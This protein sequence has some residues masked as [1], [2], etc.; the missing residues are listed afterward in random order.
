MQYK[1][2][3]DDKDADLIVA[4]C[5]DSDSVPEAV[6]RIRQQFPGKSYDSVISLLR[7]RGKPMPKELVKKPYTFKKRVA[8][9][10]PEIADEDTSPESE[11]IEEEPSTLRSERIPNI[12]EAAPPSSVRIERK[13]LP[14]RFWIDE[15]DPDDFSPVITPEND[16][17]SRRVLLI[18]DTHRPYHSRRAFGLLLK[19]AIEII[20][21]DTLVILGDFGDFYAASQHDKDP[22]RVSK[23][24]EELD[25]VAYGLDALDSI[26]GVK[27]KVYCSGNH[28]W[29]QARHIAKYAPELDGLVVSWSEYLQLGRRGWELIPYKRIGIVGNMLVTHETGI[30]GM[31]APKRVLD[32]TASMGA[33]DIAFGHTHRLGMATLGSFNGRPRISVSCGWLGSHK[34]ADYVHAIQAFSTYN[35]GFAYAV[36]DDTGHLIPGLAYIYGNRAHVLGQTVVLPKG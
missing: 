35:H 25:D 12:V 5:K 3:S 2:S 34:S 20:K 24:K 19:A 28:E 30:G 1:W 10:I 8:D 18:P 15:E 11:E 27:R 6:E 36:A 14:D 32:L 13:E 9:A 22:R 16:W 17:V 29:R 33:T 7:R 31:H 26:P 23:L 21:P 4:L